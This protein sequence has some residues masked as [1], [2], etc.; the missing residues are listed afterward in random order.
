MDVSATLYRTAS[1]ENLQGNGTDDENNEISNCARNKAV[2][3]TGIIALNQFNA[4]YLGHLPAPPYFNFMRKKTCNLLT[5]NR[6]LHEKAPSRKLIIMIKTPQ[7]AENGK[8]SPAQV[9]FQF[10]QTGKTPPHIFVAKR[11]HHS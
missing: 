8:L 1:R 2:S 3:A 7:P 4:A 9:P 6:A 5:I 10:D 11:D